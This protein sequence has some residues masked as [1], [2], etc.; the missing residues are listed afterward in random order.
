M[1]HR[2]RTSESKVRLSR[3]SADS[4]DETPDWSS[5]TQTGLPLRAQRLTEQSPGTHSVPYRHMYGILTPGATSPSSFPERLPPR[6]KPPIPSS[7]STNK[8][9]RR[10]LKKSSTENPLH[11]K[12]MQNHTEVTT[13]RHPRG[14]RYSARVSVVS[15]HHTS[16]ELTTKYHSHGISRKCSGKHDKPSQGSTS[17]S[18]MDKILGLSELYS[19]KYAYQNPFVKIISSSNPLI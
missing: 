14:E 18:T 8:I 10:K 16:P 12:R 17:A 9:V 3:L 13:R 1:Q 7:S 19:L 15:S 11:S 5:S 2:F 6:R 4:D